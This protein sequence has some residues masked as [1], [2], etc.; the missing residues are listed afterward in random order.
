LSRV[1]ARPR[2]MAPT[3]ALFSTSVEIKIIYSIPI[4]N[5]TALWPRKIKVTTFIKG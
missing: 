4:M 3:E 2:Q 5:V 1:Q